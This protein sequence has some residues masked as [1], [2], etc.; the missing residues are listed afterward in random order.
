LVTVFG[1]ASQAGR[2]AHRTLS[3]VQLAHGVAAALTGSAVFL[4]LALAV[5]VTVFYPRQRQG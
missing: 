4:A 3:P 5:A 2:S 1:A